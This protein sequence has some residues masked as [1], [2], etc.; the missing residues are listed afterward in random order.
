MPHSV[1]FSWFLS[2]FIVSKVELENR[3]LVLAL[4]RKIPGSAGKNIDFRLNY[5]PECMVSSMH[6]LKISGE[7]S[8]SPSTD[9]YP[10]SISGM[11]L[12][13]EFRPQFSGACAIDRFGFRPQFTPPTCLLTLPQQKGTRSN[14]VVPQPQLLVF[15]NTGPKISFQE[16]SWIEIY[17]WEIIDCM[18]RDLLEKPLIQRH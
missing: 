5:T 11:R 12:R 6:F 16:C 2:E 4:L 9:F 15:P 17:H 14:T 1:K 8:P 3:N 18:L 7:G 10:R 13:F